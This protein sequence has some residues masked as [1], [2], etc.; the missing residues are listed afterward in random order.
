M[1]LSSK[2][3]SQESPQKK[4]KWYTQ[5]FNVKWLTDTQLKDWLQQ[6]RDN[7]DYSYCKCCK[8]TQKMQTNLCYF[9]IKNQNNTKGAIKLQNLLVAFLSFLLRK[10]LQKRNR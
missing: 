5:V 3:N 8:I 6:D 4:I 1:S 10:T 9:D 2:S 7:K